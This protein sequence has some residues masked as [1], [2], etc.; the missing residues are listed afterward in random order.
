MVECNPFNLTENPEELEEDL[1]FKD[2]H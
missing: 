2:E 1:T